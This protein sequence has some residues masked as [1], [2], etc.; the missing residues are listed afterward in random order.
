MAFKR[1]WVQIPSPPLGKWNRIEEKPLGYRGFFRS[2][3]LAVVTLSALATPVVYGSQG[4]V[5]SVAYPRDQTHAAAAPPVDARREDAAHRD[6]GRRTRRLPEH[7]PVEAGQA[8]VAGRAGA[9]DP[10]RPAVPA[11]R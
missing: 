1:S 10:G 11:G 6:L 5:S 4:L 9:F 3:R 8:R 2:R 7:P